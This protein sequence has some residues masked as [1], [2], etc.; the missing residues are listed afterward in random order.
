[1]KQNIETESLLQ[2][3]ML[4]FLPYFSIDHFGNILLVPDFVSAYHANEE[5]QNI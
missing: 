1:M 2:L 4:I 3:I 5:I